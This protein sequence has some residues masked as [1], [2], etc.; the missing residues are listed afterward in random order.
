M[1]VKKLFLE[2][3]RAPIELP[4]L[5]GAAGRTRDYKHGEREHHVLKVLTV[6]FHSG[7]ECAP[8]STTR[9]ID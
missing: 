9:K 3:A 8:R 6:F 1:T 7:A 4:D 5:D 2:V